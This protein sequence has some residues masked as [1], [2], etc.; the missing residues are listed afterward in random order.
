MNRGGGGRD[1][2]RRPRRRD[3]QGRPVDRR[4]ARGVRRLR[5]TATGRRSAIACTSCAAT[6]TPT[7]ASTS[8]PATS[9]SSCRASTSPCSTPSLPER[10]TGHLR[11]EQID[12]LDAAAAASTVPV[13]V[14]GHHQQC[15]SGA[16]AAPTTS[17]STPTPATPSPTSCAGARRSSP[18]PP[19]TPTATA[20]AGSTATIP[21][22]E[23]G[24]VKDFPGTWAEYRVY[25]GGIL[26]VVHRMSTPEAL[27]WSEQ[28]RDLYSDFGVD[29]ADVRDGLARRSAASRSRCAD[30][31]VV[32]SLRAMSE[33]DAAEAA[34][35]A[36]LDAG[37]T[38]ADA[39]V[40][41]R[42]YESMTA[43]N[44]DVEDVGQNEDAGIGVRALVGSGWGFYAVPDLDDAVGPPGRVA[45]DGD[46]HVERRGVPGRRRRCWPA[47]RTSGR[48]P[49]SASPT[50]SASRWRRR[51]TCSCG[52]RRRWSSTAPTW[53]RRCTRSGTPPSGSCRARGTA[54]T[55]GSASAAPGSWRRRSVTARRSAARTRR[56]AASTA[57]GA[58]RWSTRS[59]SRPTPPASPRSPGPCCRRRCARAARRR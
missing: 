42:R 37:A 8:T 47:R 55:S 40:M 21:S 3:R 33:F 29:Y 52:P 6:T 1:G 53:P 46:R 44:G 9:G 18:T 23:V 54:S 13:L 31:L 22:I 10:S 56:R 12:W 41:H 15:V 43:R 35:Q 28:C 30:D 57:R 16:T 11:P 27:A 39:R 38:Y 58:G 49:A 20:S 50:R 36:A 24:C 25:D 5:G 26:Q 32:G 2:G 45:G 14:M 51:A 34:V 19:A 7:A 48:G 17:A 59:T 4:H